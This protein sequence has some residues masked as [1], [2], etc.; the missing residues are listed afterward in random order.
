MKLFVAL[1]LPES[2]DMQLSWLGGGIHGA[3]WEPAEKLHLTLRYLGEVDGGERKQVEAALERVDFESFPL[4]IRGVGHFPPRGQPR[5]VWAGVDDASQLDRLHHRIGHALDAIGI[6]GDRRKFAP[7]V[8]LAR[9]RHSPEQEV[10]EFLARHALLSTPPWTV[11]AFAL[12][13][14]TRGPRGSKYAIERVYPLL[15]AADGV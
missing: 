8:T 11:D 15:R 12:Y 1:D 3:R 4:A 6:D 2:V 10:A 5:S 9:L 14:S 7:H 13:S